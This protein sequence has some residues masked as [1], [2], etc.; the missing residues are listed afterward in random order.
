MENFKEQLERKVW[1]IVA[2]A[3]GWMMSPLPFWVSRHHPRLL[4]HYIAWRE[5]KNLKVATG[6]V[7]FLGMGDLHRTRVRK[8]QRVIFGI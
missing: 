7:D 8:L 1:N 5:E 4:G 2:I 3:A 6:L